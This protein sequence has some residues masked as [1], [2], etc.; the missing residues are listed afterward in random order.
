MDVLCYDV[1]NLPIIASTWVLHN[2]DISHQNII[3]HAS[4]IC[5]S[6]KWVGKKQVHSSSIHDNQGRFNKNIYDDYH[7][8]SEFHKIL[9]SDEDFV[10]LAHNG[11]RFDIK[12]LNTSFLNHGLDPVP[13][14]QS[15]DTLL[16]ARRKFRIDSNR[17]D[18]L[19][20]FLG[21]GE[22]V[23]TGGYQ[24]WN[25]IVQLKYPE[26][27]KSPDKDKALKALDK[28]VRYNR[29]DVTLLES[30]YLKMKPY[31]KTP[32]A[33]LYNP[34][35]GDARCPKCLSADWKP[36]GY[37]Y[38]NISKIRRYRCRDCRT[39]FTERT[40]DYRVQTKVA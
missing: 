36:S 10:L 23:E 25:D 30:V 21:V 29:R 18:Y 12:K 17:L 2:A 26:V 24:L 38:T 39:L 9:S 15:I 33:L 37:R 6:W 8:V 14:R 32:N 35:A 16:E 11:N 28:M 3:E 40:A 4:I 22:K 20:R 27:G 19:G 13:E 31:I 1:E 5:V 7:P 34:K